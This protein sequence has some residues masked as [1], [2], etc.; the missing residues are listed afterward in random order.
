MGPPAS[1]RIRPPLTGAS[2]RC[3]PYVA[4][5]RA[6]ARTSSGEIVL[7]T[8]IVAPAGIAG[9]TPAGPKRTSHAP[10]A[11][12]QAGP[13]QV[14]ALAY[15]GEGVDHPGRAG[16]EWVERLGGA[17]TVQSTPAAAMRAATGR[18]LVAQPDKTD[19][20]Q[21]SSALCSRIPLD[22]TLRCPPASQLM[23]CPVM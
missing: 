16:A 10:A 7:C 14:D 8:A 4:A 9:A 21:S 1:A 20:H 12:Q 13:E 18:A 3:R 22:Q 17:H 5:S 2:S 19:A 15:V 11:L 6:S 23:N